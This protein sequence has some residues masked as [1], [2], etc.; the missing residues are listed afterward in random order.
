MHVKKA[1]ISKTASRNL[2]QIIPKCKPKIELLNGIFVNF[3][4]L[5]NQV[6]D[7]WNL[8]FDRMPSIARVHSKYQK[9]I[10]IFYKYYY[11]L[12]LLNV[13]KPFYTNTLTGHN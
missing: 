7:F 10:S 1:I 6:L 2:K 8:G 5:V 3:N 4:F 13:I 11:Q 9:Y 12:I